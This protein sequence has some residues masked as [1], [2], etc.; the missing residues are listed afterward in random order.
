LFTFAGPH[1]VT[2]IS[3]TSLFSSSFSSFSHE[4]L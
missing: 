2:A 4:S 1:T 3:R